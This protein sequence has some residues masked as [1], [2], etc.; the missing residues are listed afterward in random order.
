MVKSHTPPR[1]GFVP[2]VPLYSSRRG[3]PRAACPDVI[4]VGQRRLH[5]AVPPTYGGA[6]AVETTMAKKPERLLRPRHS[7]VPSYR[8]PPYGG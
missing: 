1:S 2:C 5:V 4:S 6:I 8:P 3:W 7:A